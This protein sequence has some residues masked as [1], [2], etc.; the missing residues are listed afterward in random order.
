[1]NSLT[2]YLMSCSGMIKNNTIISV[3][4]F[5]N[6]FK[7]RQNINARFVHYVLHNS[8]SCSQYMLVRAPFITFYALRFLQNGPIVEDMEDIYLRV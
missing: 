5:I 1:M 7:S 8:K 4:R 2:Q 6:H 3:T